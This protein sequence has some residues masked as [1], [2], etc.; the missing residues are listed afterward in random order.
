M[1]Q[2]RGLSIFYWLPGH[3]VSAFQ[4]ICTCVNRRKGRYQCATTKSESL[5]D[6]SSRS[7]TFN[8]RSM[9]ERFVH[10]AQKLT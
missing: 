6:P 5:T 1:P 2:T 8:M 4:T 10:R 9:I 7:L 3:T